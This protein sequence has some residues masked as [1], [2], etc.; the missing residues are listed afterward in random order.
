MFT[1]DKV[2]EIF[3][4]ADEFN[5]V[6]C[7][8]LEKYSLNAPKENL[9]PRWTPLCSRCY[10]HHVLFPNSGCHCLKHFYLNEESVNLIH[11][12]PEVVSY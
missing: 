5:K 1:A 3:F 8:M 2:T 11:L 4:M 6:F 10:D 7:Y 9:S 12:F